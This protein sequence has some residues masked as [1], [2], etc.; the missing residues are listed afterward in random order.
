MSDEE[1][2]KSIESSLQVDDQESG[3]SKNKISIN[4]LS[5]GKISEVDEISANKLIEREDNDD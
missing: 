5:L 4:K 3:E 1:S 2:S